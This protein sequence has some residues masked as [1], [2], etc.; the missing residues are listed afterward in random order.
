MQRDQIA[1]FGN[2]LV[3]ILHELELLVTIVPVQL[4]ALADDFEEVDNANRPVALM[5]AQLAMIGMI[6]CNQRIDARV[7]R[8]LKLIELK[9]ALERGKYAQIDA[10]QSGRRSLQLDQL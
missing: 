9:L 6:D 2:D 10:L 4:H 3:G 8:R 5:C 7:A 1:A